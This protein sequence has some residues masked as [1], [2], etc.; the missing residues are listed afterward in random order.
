MKLFYYIL[1][2]LFVAMAK[3]SYSRDFEN[4]HQF[5]SGD[6]LSADVFNDLFQNISDSKKTI[7]ENNLVGVWDCTSFTG[8]DA[9]FISGWQVDG[10]GL[11]SSLE[12]T[13]Q[14]IDNGNGTFSVSSPAPNPILI[15]N[16]QGIDS[17]YLVKADMLLLEISSEY[18]VSDLLIQ[19]VSNTRLVLK[20]PDEGSIVD[21]LIC[22]L[23]NLPPSHPK[24]LS[25]TLSDHTV[26]LTWNDDSDDETGFKIVRRDSLTGDFTEI[27][28]STTASYTDTLTSDGKYWYR[29][30]ATNENG[31]S[32]GSNVAKVTL[33][34]DD[35]S[36]QLRN[37]LRMMKERMELI[38]SELSGGDQ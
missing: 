26:T 9:S 22:D 29:V 24:Q 23:Q 2:I 17:Y 11:V 38:E 18:G 37:E 15:G 33:G 3:T 1:F 30:M 4:P 7:T 25:A 10:L 28:T 34:D 13:F 21:A 6:V 19:K 12:T 36:Q 14:F 20:G 16:L 32:L 5:S 35:D 31:D 8:G 27:G